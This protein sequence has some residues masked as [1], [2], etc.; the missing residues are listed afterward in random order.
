MS[1]PAAPPEP[2]PKSTSPPLA[3]DVE[4]LD[5]QCTRSELLWR[6]YADNREYAR[7]HEAQRSTAANL[8]VVIAAGL[9]GLATFDQHLTMADLPLTLFLILVG[10]FGA[11]FSSKHY[12]RTR[13]HLNRAKK[14]LRR[15]DE[16][17][18][19]ER[20]VELQQQGD[21]ENARAFPRLY[22]MKLNNLWNV[23]YAM[24][25]LLGVLLSAYI[26]LS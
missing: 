22:S 3:E 1:T 9:L 25:A 2:S 5:A 4:Q 18:P 26:V 10:S 21:A 20:I 17:F 16:L 7:A 24:L 13:L 19:Q 11:L 15:L 8:I 23:F 6:L 12:E 14:Y